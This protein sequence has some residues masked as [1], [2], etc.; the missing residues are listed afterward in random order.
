[1]PHTQPAANPFALMM[2]PE[3]IFA[4]IEGS[5]RLQRLK[6]RI[7]RPLDEPRVAGSAEMKACDDESIES[8]DALAAAEPEVEAGEGS[9]PVSTG[10]CGASIAS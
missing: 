1:M 10:A 2:D 8:L 5:E 4:A 3:A 9:H 7:C 6:S